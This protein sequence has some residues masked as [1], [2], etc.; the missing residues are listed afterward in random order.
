MGQ[1]NSYNLL[2]SWIPQSFPE[3]YHKLIL[4]VCKTYTSVFDFSPTCLET[5][6]VVEELRGKG[7]TQSGHC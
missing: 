7:G 4:G 1:D 2:L 6:T 5:E 3:S